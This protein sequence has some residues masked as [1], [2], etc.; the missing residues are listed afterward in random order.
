MLM[1]LKRIFFTALG[2]LGLSAVA[3][4]PVVAQTEIPA[5]ESLRDLTTCIEMNTPDPMER[6]R[7]PVELPTDYGAADLS[8]SARALYTVMACTDIKL[9]P[10]NRFRGWG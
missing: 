4:G 9:D 3:V 10:E 7:R 8:V 5:P 6:M 1:V 2:A